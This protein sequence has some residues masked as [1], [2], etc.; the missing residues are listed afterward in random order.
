MEYKVN[1]YKRR[2]NIIQ[3]DFKAKKTG[4][5]N[6]QIRQSISLIYVRLYECDS[7][8]IRYSG[9]SGIPLTLKNVL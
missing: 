7:G 2:N 4:L 5:S 3:T 8:D 9:M 6:I 1:E